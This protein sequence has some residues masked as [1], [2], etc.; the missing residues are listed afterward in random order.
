MKSKTLI[1]TFKGTENKN[2]ESLVL[3]IFDE[4]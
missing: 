2:G 4:N 3:L 1:Y